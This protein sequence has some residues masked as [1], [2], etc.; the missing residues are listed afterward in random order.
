M[1]NDAGQNQFITDPQRLATEFNNYFREKIDLLHLK[2]ERPPDIDPTSRLRTWLEKEN[3]STPRFQIKEIDK[4]CF[5]KLMQ[6]F[7]GKRV[8]GVDLI[9]SYSIKIAAPLIEDALI[10]L[11]NLSIKQGKF[12]DI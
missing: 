9:D 10:H 6:K 12:A 7:K 4:M 8:H 5:R 2:T 11:I 1:Q 3:I